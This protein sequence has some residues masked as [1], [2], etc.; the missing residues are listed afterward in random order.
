MGRFGNGVRCM[1]PGVK[2]LDQ[3]ETLSPSTRLPYH[4]EHINTVSHCRLVWL[5]AEGMWSVKEA[6]HWS[7]LTSLE[8]G[9]ITDQHSTITISQHGPNMLYKTSQDS[10]NW[11]SRKTPVRHHLTP[12]PA[13]SS[14]KGLSSPATSIPSLPTSSSLAGCLPTRTSCSP[15]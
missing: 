1:G 8:C 7:D 3:V 14:L 4:S 5:A 9:A 6:A 15:L 12:R 13:S 11:M 2:R 10:F